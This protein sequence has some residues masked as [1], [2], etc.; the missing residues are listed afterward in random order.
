MGIDFGLKMME[1]G[2][3]G[4]PQMPRQCV[5]PPRDEGK[6]TGEGYM[7]GKGYMED[8]IWCSCWREGLKGINCEEPRGGT[9]GD[10]RNE[11]FVKTYDP[12]GAGTGLCHGQC[13][14]RV[15]LGRVDFGMTKRA[16]LYF[17]LC[18]LVFSD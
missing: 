18:N 8:G 4:I 6:E 2:K 9:G 5:L 14:R 3:E 7:T 12:G 16:L 13:I 10:R 11:Y 15:D 1:R 17:G